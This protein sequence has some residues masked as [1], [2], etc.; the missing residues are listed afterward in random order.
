[1][2]LTAGARISD[3]AFLLLFASE[4][5]F[6]LL[7]LQTGVVE[8]HHSD[9]HALWMLPVGGLIGIV[10][11][12]FLYNER[13]LLIPFV[14]LIQLVLSLGYAHTNGF[15][16]FLFGLISGLTAPL[17]IAR[18]DNFL[19]IVLALALSYTYGTY[20]FH[21]PAADRTS[22]AVL[23]SLVALSASLFSQMGR[24]RTASEG[25]DAKGA[26]TIFFWLLLDAA[27]FETLSRNSLMSI[28]G[29]MHFTWIIIVFHLVGIAVAYTLRDWNRNN[30]ALFL[31]F[32]LT[33]GLYAFHLRL[34]LSIVYPFVISYYNVILLR[35][36]MRLRY[37]A[38]AMVALSLWIASGLG[39]MIALSGEF[40]VAWAV[41]AVLGVIYL[42]QRKS[43]ES[44]S[45]T[46]PFRRLMAHGS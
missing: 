19:L 23:L 36:L 2:K 35:R 16:L 14:L 9:M 46:S 27:L 6:Y 41:L 7:I 33:Y 4:F 28:W 44:F 42:S 24:D 45:F 29:E 32:V 8:Y 1:M 34:E 43:D 20:H 11:S 15:E 5:T 10:S 30:L 21:I 12:I 37:P 31:L 13:T 39:L 22:I 38:L 26:T 40:L 17:L 25:Y 3:I 18:I